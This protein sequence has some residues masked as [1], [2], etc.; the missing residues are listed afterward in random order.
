MTSCAGHSSPGHLFRSSAFCQGLGVNTALHEILGEADGSDMIP[1]KPFLFFGH[2]RGILAWT[3]SAGFP[4]AATDRMGGT[5]TAAQGRVES[6]AL[7]V[8]QRCVDVVLGNIGAGQCWVQG[9]A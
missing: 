6:P 7:E 4:K 8:F 9:W 5:G 3:G 1:L 2:N